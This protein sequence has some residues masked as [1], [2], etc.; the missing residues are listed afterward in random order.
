MDEAASQIAPGLYRWSAPH[1]EWRPGA[2]PGGPDDWDELVGSV[3]FEA[4]DVA[5]LIDPQ[6]PPEGGERERLL[7]WLDDRIGQRP[8]SVL[9]TISEHRRDR[10]ALAARYAGRSSR[11]WNAV[12]PGV[13]PKPL[14][15]A[16]ETAYWLADAGALVFGDRLLGDGAGGVR[17]P[18]E[19][20]LED[21]R[22]DRAGLA[23][24]M[25]PLLELGVERL[26][27][28]HGEPVLHD[29]RAALARAIRE[30]EDA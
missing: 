1:P 10:E 12:P 2:S 23:R 30:A 5:V 4:N 14:R 16:G 13:A 9:T 20:W 8:V 7:A 18:P 25:R 11:A 29:G 26:L 19:S 3:L 24:Q 6:L 21:V 28:S 17:L 27:V 15:G 22:I